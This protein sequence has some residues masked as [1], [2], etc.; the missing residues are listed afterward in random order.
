MLEGKDN[1]QTLPLPLL[2]PNAI[3]VTSSL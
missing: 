1:N 3:T 2:T